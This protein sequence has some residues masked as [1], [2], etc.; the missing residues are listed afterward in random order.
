MVVRLGRLFRLRPHGFRSLSS[1]AAAEFEHN[2]LCGGFAGIG[3]RVDHGIV[4]RDITCL[5]VDHRLWLV[6]VFH[7]YVRIGE[8]NGKEVRQMRVLRIFCARRQIDQSDGPLIG[9]N[10]LCHGD[11]LG[12]VSGI[13]GHRD[14]ARLGA[15]FLIGGGLQ[16]FNRSIMKRGAGIVG[17]GMHQPG[18][19]EPGVAILQSNLRRLRA[20]LGIRDLGVAQ[21]NA[22]IV[23]AVVVHQR[24]LSR[25]N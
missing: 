16:Q 24:R 6:L 7:A 5:G 21:R 9:G 1:G 15:G 12:L 14:F 4:P 11:A 25:I 23:M 3:Y 22:K 2:R 18:G 19:R 20:L 10:E 17:N 13:A 8:R